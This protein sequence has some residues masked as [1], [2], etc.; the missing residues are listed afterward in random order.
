MNAKQ[1]EYEKLKQQNDDLHVIREKYERL[2]AQALVMKERYETR[3]KEL[4]DAEP[5]AEVIGEEIKKLMNLMYKRLKV[6][7]KA[8]QFYSGNG[9]LTAMLKMIKMITLQVISKNESEE[10]EEDVD[11]FSQHIYQ[12]PPP[13]PPPSVVSTSTMHSQT[14]VDE[15]LKQE[16]KAPIQSVEESATAPASTSL[17]A[18]NA[19]FSSTSTIDKSPKQGFDEVDEKE[20]EKQEENSQTIDEIRKGFNQLASLLLNI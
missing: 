8:D 1:A 4:L 20:Q 16:V 14:S 12:A 6:Q 18:E 2:Q 7:I 17:V 15:S 11:Y 19:S 13:P 3:I 9:I 5:D 10:T